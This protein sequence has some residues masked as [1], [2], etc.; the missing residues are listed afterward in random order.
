LLSK[1][2]RWMRGNVGLRPNNRGMR[3]EAFW[4]EGKLL[5]GCRLAW[6]RRNRRDHRRL[7]AGGRTAGEMRR[8]PLLRWN[9]QGNGD[10]GW[11]EVTPRGCGR[12]LRLC[13]TDVP[14]PGRTR[15]R[16]SPA[17]SRGRPGAEL[18][19]GGPAAAPK[20]PAICGR[21]R[22]GAAEAAVPGPR[23]PTRTPCAASAR[24][25]VIKWPSE[26]GG[27]GM[28]QATAGRRA[29]AVLQSKS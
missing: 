6:Q 23:D 17:A 13:R 10:L 4:L 28:V 26:G 27:A 15:E 29:A 16:L 22:T 19:E 21:A 2:L 25:V 11:A 9:R 12:R 8:R 1:N 20:P 24:A 7:L 3:P 5:G 18:A 14:R